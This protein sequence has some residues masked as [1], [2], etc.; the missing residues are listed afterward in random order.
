MTLA[1][2]GISLLPD[3]FVEEDIQTGRLTDLFP[4]DLNERIGL[5]TLLPVRRQ[6][7]PA[8]RAFADYIYAK[9]AKDFVA[10]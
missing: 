9:L 5:Y 6:I 3:F 4:G 7:T 8:A 2:L 1:G 10:K